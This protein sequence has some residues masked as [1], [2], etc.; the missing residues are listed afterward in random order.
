MLLVMGALMLPLPVPVGLILVVVGL[1]LLAHDSRRIRSRIV[2]LGRRHPEVRDRALRIAISISR[3][4]GA[5]LHRLSG[6]IPR[7]R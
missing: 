4:L 1:A 7:G 2:R 3:P 6:R 5:Y